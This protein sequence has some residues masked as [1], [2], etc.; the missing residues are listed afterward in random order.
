MSRYFES[1]SRMTRTMSS[2][3]SPLTWTAAAAPPCSSAIVGS[4]LA[5]FS[6]HYKHCSTENPST[7]GVD[8]HDQLDSASSVFRYISH[9]H[10]EA[11]LH[12][13]FNTLHG[14]ER[15]PVAFNY[16][17]FNSKLRRSLRLATESRFFFKHLFYLLL[18]STLKRTHTLVAC[19]V[20]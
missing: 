15:T 12:V 5:G 3:T 4:I 20:V 11:K 13:V 18:L 7:R 9:H 14:P 1:N 10:T 19:V 6:L 17:C 16:S 2:R 8:L